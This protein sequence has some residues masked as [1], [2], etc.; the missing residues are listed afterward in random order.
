MMRPSS[1]QLT[2]AGSRWRSSFRKKFT[3][4]SG[5]LRMP[6]TKYTIAIATVSGDISTPNSWHPFFSNFCASSLPIFLSLWV[7][8]KLLPSSSSGCFSPSLRHWVA[9]VRGSSA[10]KIHYQ[11]KQLES[12]F[13]FFDGRREHNFA[14]TTSSI[15]TI[16]QK[17][18]MMQLTWSTID[19]KHWSLHACFWSD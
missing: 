19:P 14:F 6:C 10:E 3:A 8:L 18:A 12:A 16:V 1:L 15:M 9:F 7:T 11:H 13:F 2:S 17:P 4:R 5:R